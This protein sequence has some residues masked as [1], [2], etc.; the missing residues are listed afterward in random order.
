MGFRDYEHE[1]ALVKFTSNLEPVWYGMTEEQL[2][3]KL[4][5]DIRLLE[6]LSLENEC[7]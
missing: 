4:G 2:K 6:P 7:N 3:D 5:I 1:F